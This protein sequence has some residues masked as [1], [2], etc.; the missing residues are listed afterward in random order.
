MRAWECTLICGRAV[1]LFARWFH[2][3]SRFPCLYLVCAEK[4]RLRPPTP[5]LSVRRITVGS[6]PRRGGRWGGSD[7]YSIKEVKQTSSFP[8]S[9]ANSRIKKNLNLK[10]KGGIWQFVSSCQNDH[11]ISTFATLRGLSNGHT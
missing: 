10:K 8:A 5:T 6:C 4:H 3:I 7:N 9:N 2:F 1:R 11:G